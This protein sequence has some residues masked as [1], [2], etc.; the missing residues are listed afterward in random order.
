MYVCVFIHQ[1]VNFDANKCYVAVQWKAD[2]CNL[3][4]VVEN[5]NQ[6][7]L[8]E[9]SF[10]LYTGT[11]GE[12]REERLSTN[13]NCTANQIPCNKEFEIDKNY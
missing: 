5:Y 2:N 6:I 12:I 9:F 1:A 11:V 10:W 3:T 13:P 4:N 7:S 8:L